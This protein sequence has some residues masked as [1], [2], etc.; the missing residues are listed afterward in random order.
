MKRRLITLLLLLAVACSAWAEQFVIT[1]INE[2]V[3][4]LK[5]KDKASGQPL[6]SS[7]VNTRKTVN[8][9]GEPF[10]YIED[11][12]SGVYG[13]D[14]TVKSWK[15]VAYV[16]LSGNYLLPYSVKLTVKDKNGQVVTALEKNYDAVS[17]KVACKIN[18]QTK[19][20]DFAA[21][22]IDKEMMGPVLTN[23]PLNKSSLL[24]K[25]L[26]HEPSLYTMTLKY[27]GDEVVNGANCYKL[28]MIPDLGA[29]N[30]LGAF[31]PK[32]YFWYKKA[33]PHDFVRY[34]GLESGLGTP[35]IVMEADD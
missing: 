13:K 2:G 7:K 24:F 1:R 3:K 18:G 34:E 21:D 28:E 14:K 12:G 22:L 25:L 4:G 30:L 31:V 26:T 35:Y 23:Y 27:L 29:L 33:A 32:T 19:I 20:Y 9:K 15:T 6:W 17:K 16:R 8:A 11:N 10:L 5:A